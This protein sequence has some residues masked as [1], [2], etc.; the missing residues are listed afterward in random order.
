MKADSQQQ[1]GGGIAVPQREL[2]GDCKPHRCQ[3]IQA[4]ETLVNAAAA[5]GKAALG[6][7]CPSS[8]PWEPLLPQELLVA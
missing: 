3:G 5:A 4:G 7:C 6:A 2:T 8:R 1:G